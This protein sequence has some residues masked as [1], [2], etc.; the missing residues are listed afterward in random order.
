VARASGNLMLV[1]FVDGT[2]LISLRDPQAKQFVVYNNQDSKQAFP[3]A[4]KDIVQTSVDPSHEN[5]DLK[6]FF[7][8]SEGGLR[9][10]SLSNTGREQEVITSRELRME[11]LR[12][13]SAC[14]GIIVVF[15]PSGIFI[16][17]QISEPKVFRNGS[18]VLV[19]G[20]AFWNVRTKRLCVSTLSI[21]AFNYVKLSVFHLSENEERLVPV[22]CA[23]IGFDKTNLETSRLVKFLC[24]QVIGVVSAD[25][26]LVIGSPSFPSKSYNTIVSL[27]GVVTAIV[28][29]FNVLFLGTSVGKVYAYKLRSFTDMG[30]LQLKEF[31]WSSRS[32]S[33]SAVTSIDFYF[34]DEEATVIFSTSEDVFVCDWH[35]H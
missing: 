32:E 6:V 26:R 3:T 2:L 29:R 28:I 1:G 34:C 24:D 31:D 30:D 27:E 20:Y 18:D 4:V 35:F 25:G 14:N 17:D 8:I 22:A 21:D 16:W 33:C 13:A 23:T 7:A 15:A 5:L 10:Y 19:T 11:D 9:M 12:S